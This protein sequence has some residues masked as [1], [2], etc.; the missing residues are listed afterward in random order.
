MSTR[1]DSFFDIIN[2]RSQTPYLTAAWQHFIG[3]EYDPADFADATLDFVQRWDWDWVKINPR[4]VY[5]AEAWG[6]RYD[7]DNYAGVVPTLVEPAITTPDD[8]TRITPLKPED[9]PAFADQIAAARA[10]KT[11]LPDR[12]VVQ[13]LFSPLT[14]LLQLAGLPTYPDDGTPAPGL[15]RADLLGHPQA[16]PALATI[17]RTLADYTAQLLRPAG[18]GGAGL[19]GIFYAV[20]GT[21]S[22]SFFT[23]QQFDQFSAPY[24][25]QVLDAAQPGAVVFHTCRADSHPDWFADWPVSALQWDQ[26]LPGNPAADVDLGPATVAGPQSGLF[27]P[28]QDLEQLAAELAATLHA[29]QG[30]PFLLAPSCTIPTP[31]SNTALELLRQ[32]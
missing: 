5:Y 16:G 19:D 31:A 12:A 8:L 32:A 21:A 26:A 1:R 22:Q 25:R 6:S 11:A 24:D 4:A 7:P 15:T 28:G 20:T 29:R 23:R 27:G 2:N 17:T 14:V 3:R 13:T 10:I 18:E 30:K 9:N